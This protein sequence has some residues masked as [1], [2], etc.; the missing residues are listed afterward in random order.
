MVYLE[1]TP[2]SE[3]WGRVQIVPLDRVPYNL[4]ISLLSLDELR[5]FVSQ[6]SSLAQQELGDP[7]CH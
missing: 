2:L 7:R 3:S 4:G 1:Q 6:V 5:K